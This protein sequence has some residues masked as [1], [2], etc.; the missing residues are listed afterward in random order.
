LA[1]FKPVASPEGADV[2]VQVALISRQV[3]SPWR[4]RGPFWPYGRVGMGGWYGG[5]GHLG[6]GL[7]MS[8]EPPLSEVQVDV[9]IRDKRSNQVLY[10][11]HAV[12]Q[13]NA[14]W[15]ES[16]MAPLFEGALKDFP[17]PAISP[18]LV[19]IPMPPKGAASR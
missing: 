1:G 8:L 12:R 19:T 18:R 16:V 7:G 4:D 15:D 11:T 17:T 14:G 10:E 2:L 13:Q 9:L 5:G 3:P 6:F